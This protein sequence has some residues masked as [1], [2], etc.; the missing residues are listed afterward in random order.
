VLDDSFTGL[1]TEIEAI[2][3]GVALLQQ[4][5]RPQALQIVFEAAMTAHAFVERLLAGVTEGRVTKVMRQRNSFGKIFVELQCARRSAGDL[6]DL[7]AVRQARPE[8]VTF[9]VDENLGLVF[10]PPERRRVN[11]AVAVALE[12]AA[13]RMLRRLAVR[14][15]ATAAVGCRD[16]VGRKFTHR[17]SGQR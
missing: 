9:V 17:P 2:K 14:V 7:E 12:L 3:S 13:V 10:E 8:Q 11:D 5:N 6:R 15:P 4:V 1:E 16:G